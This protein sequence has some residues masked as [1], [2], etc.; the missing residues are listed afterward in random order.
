MRSKV[1]AEKFLDYV[2]EDVPFFDITSELIEEKVR[3]KAAI[4]AK[5]DFILVGLE[6][7]VELLKLVGINVKQ[8][9]KD[10][11]YIKEGEKIAILEGSARD[12]LGVERLI[13]NIIS[14]SSGIATVTN[15]LV[16]LCKT[17][18]QKVRIA[19]TRKTLPGLRYLEKKAVRIGGG[20]THRMSLS[21]M[22]LLKDNHIRII[23][24]IGEAVKRAKEKASIS[25]KVEVE[26]SSSEEAIEAAKCGVDIIML[27]NFTVEEV[28]ETINKLDELKLREK[29][30]I[31]VSGRINEENILEYAGCDVD[32][33][34]SG[35]ITHSARAVDVSLE[36]F[37]VLKP[38]E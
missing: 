5:Q 16:K 27:D 14:H 1:E 28:K 30:L 33:I 22:I 37:E 13:L 36:V 21:D 20:D 4:Q 19:A 2:R 24:G 18:N 15:R 38:Q 29:V 35:A 32:I 12:I 6:E 11:D 10:G 31:E 3:C 17:V 26:V 25:A 8:L 9:K 34:S 23:G 7:S